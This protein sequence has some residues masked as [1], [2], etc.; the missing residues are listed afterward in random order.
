M[1]VFNLEIPKYTTNQHDKQSECSYLPD[2]GIIMMI[3]SLTYPSFKRTSVH[4]NHDS[5]SMSALCVIKMLIEQYLFCNIS[6]K[7]THQSSLF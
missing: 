4:I 2:I 3:R 1:R 5:S 6:M 7:C